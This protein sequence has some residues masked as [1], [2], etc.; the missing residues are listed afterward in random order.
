ME[1]GNIIEQVRKNKGLTIKEVCGEQISRSVYNRFV[2]NKADTSTS[3]LT[4]LLR[5]LNLEY[6]E[7]K[8][9]NYPNETNQLQQI[10]LMI[11]QAFERKDIDSLKRIRL[12]C[13]RDTGINKNKFKHLSNICELIIGR[14]TNENVDVQKMEAFNYLMA[15][16]SWTHYELVLFNNMM[17]AFNV[18][19]VEVILDN[20]ILN[21]KRHSTI[22][23]Y[24]NE[25]FRMIL[26][27]V[28]F[29]IAEGEFKLVGK[30]MGILKS[31]YLNED[32]FFEK[33]MLLFIEGIF[34]HIFGDEN[35]GNQ[36]I[37]QSLVVCKVL[38]ADN[39]F[40]MNYEF[41]ERLN[42]HYNLAIPLD[43]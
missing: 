15:V 10:S 13:L 24:G 30:Y 8:N 42:S 38:K 18:E 23:R 21:F 28:S 32:N 19:L 33:T 5:Q 11:R 7:L 34:N 31:F 36:Q 26:N 16:Q 43:E 37:N 22:D 20:A 1:L 3:N 25:S 39:L 29:F 27:A 6:D 14:L 2:N 41:V 35:M 4:Y 17:F 12:M 40:Q 9:Y